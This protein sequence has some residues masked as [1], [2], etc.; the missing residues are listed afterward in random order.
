MRRK[1]PLLHGLWLLAA[2][3]TVP[4]HAQEFPSRTIRF[5]VP[6]PPAGATDILAR[7][8]APPLNR[9]FGQNVVVDNRTGGN[10]V[11]GTEVVFRA[12]ADGHTLLVIAPSFSINPFVRTKLPYDTLKDFS[13]VARLAVV[14]LTISIHPSVP[15]K[16]VK[17]LIALARAKPGELTFATSS[18]IGG[19]RLAAELF[20]RERAK[21]EIIAV[22]Y[23]GGAPASTAVMGGHTTILVSNLAEA[24]QQ[25]NVGRLRGIAVMSLARTAQ[26]P[27]LPTVAESGYPG[28]EAANWYGAV[29]RSATPRVVIERLSAEIGKALQASEIRD[30]LIRGG[31]DLAYLGA[32]EFDTYIRGEMQR[33][34]RIVAALKLRMD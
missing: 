16:D 15:A 29:I 6:F 34:Q 13:A 17:E 28:F 2:L 14:P 23:N 1:P 22:P 7:A 9:A 30:H 12:P 11:I 24:V 25:I 26:L 8:L 19:Q 33:N 21:V 3:T 20:F 5:V 32:A 10:T 27:S 31:L 4:A 18:I